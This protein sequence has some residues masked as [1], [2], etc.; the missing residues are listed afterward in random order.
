MRTLLV[1]LVASALA[2]SLE[3]SDRFASGDRDAVIAALERMIETGE[4]HHGSHDEGELLQRAVDVAL[5]QPDE[6]VEL[7]AI[8][9][10]AVV[11]AQ[12]PL[13]VITTTD[14]IPLSIS[15]RVALKLPRPVVYRTEV[16]ASVDG[17]ETVP[18]GRINS[19]Q[20]TFELARALPWTAR[21][22]GA[23]H[24]R[25]RV[26][27]RYEGDVAPLPEYRDLPELVYAVYDPAHHS[28]A[29]ARTFVFS[30]AGTSAQQMDNR[31]PDMP[32]ALWLNSVLVARGGEPSDEFSWRIFYCDERTKEP[33]QSHGRLDLCSVFHFQLGRT[34]FGQIW[35]RT[36]RVEMTDTSVQWLAGSPTFEAIRFIYPAASE[37]YDLSHLENILDTGADQWARG[38]ASIAPEDIVITPNPRRPNTARISATIRNEG[39]IDLS[40]V[41]IQIFGGDFEEPSLNRRLLRDIPRRETIKIDLE[42]SS[43]RGYGIAVVQLMPVLSEFSPWVG[44]HPHD[45]H[46]NDMAFRVINPQRAPRGFAASI[47][48]RCG[49]QCRGY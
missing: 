34:I 19:E 4:P 39:D 21:L 27:L 29:D 44:S 15:T 42:V 40:G 30:P 16:M 24:L 26:L 33:G 25:L 22:A 43:P 31:L 48:R 2:T 9:A 41:Y 11:T 8:R 47:K 18:L 6:E 20:D 13:P 37:S 28:F 5:M 38:D 35:I 14:N 32:L 45:P 36:G 7:L 10:A 3:A 12:I 49:D 17:G 23:H 1:C 46:G